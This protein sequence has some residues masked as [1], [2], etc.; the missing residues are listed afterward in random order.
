MYHYTSPIGLLGILEKHELWATE[1]VSLNDR[2]EVSR[3]RKRLRHY[4]RALP[5]DSADDRTLFRELLRATEKD[6]NQ[7]DRDVFLLCASLERDDAGQWRLYT[8][9][10]AGYS[11]HLDSDTPLQVIT[12]QTAETQEDLWFLGFGATSSWCQVAYTRTQTD[13]LFQSLL[14]WARQR[15][16]DLSAEIARIPGSEDVLQDASAAL[17]DNFR[18]DLADTVLLACSLTKPRGFRAER[19]VRVVVVLS[20]PDLHVEFRANSQGLVRYLRLTS[21]VGGPRAYGVR[22]RSDQDRLPVTGITVGPTVGLRS[23][24]ATIKELLDRRGYPD[25]PVG[26]SSIPL[27]W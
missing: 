19:E 17:W 24:K 11:V 10:R 21:A 3:G 27:R 5:S 6:W 9:Q 25:V 7:N 26:R 15:F 20:A 12:N 18:Q 8:G 14:T 23:P 22:T 4:L 1:A 13:A 2:T 16:S